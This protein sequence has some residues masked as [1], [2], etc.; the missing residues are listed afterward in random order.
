LTI[1]RIALASLGVPGLA[2]AGAVAVDGDAADALLYTAALLV[3]VAPLAGVAC[4]SR[5][6]VPG[7]ADRR[8]FGALGPL[9]GWVLL[10]AGVSGLLT[11]VAMRPG[12]LAF[13]VSS[14]AAIAVVALA[15]SGVGALLAA[16]MFEP[17]DAAGA[18][19][20]LSVA[21]GGGVLV[22]G[23]L[24]SSAPAA[25]VRAAVDGSPFVAMLSA[26]NIDVARMDLFYRISPLAHIGVEYPA[27]S[28][29]CA[30]YGI[31]AALCFAG[32]VV[33]SR[34]RQDVQA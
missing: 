17:L 33:R 25:L 7:A 30:V 28:A 8:L 3:V 5:R 4:V 9:F 29:T 10:T 6:K 22:A 21:A 19:V 2:W 31:V 27:W 34:I 23:S 1:G 12:S 11:G 15:L 18:S 20:V 24:T 26:A 16:W 32:V 13:A 14:H